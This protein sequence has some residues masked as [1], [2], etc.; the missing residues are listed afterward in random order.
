MLLQVVELYAMGGATDATRCEGLLAAP[1][2][3]VPDLPANLRRDVAVAG[4]RSRRC[5]PGP[6]RCGQSFALALLFQDEPQ[7]FVQHR[8]QVGARELVAQGR[9]GLLEIFD[10]LAGDGHGEPMLGRRDRLDRITTP[11]RQLDRDRPRRSL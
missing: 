7:P 1:L 2:V 3:A 9:P 8:G 5:F 4:L 10:E 6:R 11:G